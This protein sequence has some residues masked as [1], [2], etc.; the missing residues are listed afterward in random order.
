MKYNRRKHNFPERGCACC[1]NFMEDS[2]DLVLGFCP[3]RDHFT[4]GVDTCNDFIKTFN[5]P[6]KN[7]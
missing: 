2:R 7:R 3:L 5:K 1:N 4:R 6:S